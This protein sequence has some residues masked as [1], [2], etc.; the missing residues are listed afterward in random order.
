M[1]DVF[2]STM[3]APDRT[4]SRTMDAS[5]LVLDNDAE[6]GWWTAISG[7][8]YDVSD[9]RDLHSGGFRII[10]DN[11]GIDSAEE[12]RTIRH[13]EDAEIQAML[14]LYRIGRAA[15]LV[16]RRRLGRRARGRRPALCWG[17]R[18]KMATV[19]LRRG[20]IENALRNEFD[21][22]DCN[23]PHQEAVKT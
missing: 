12:Y 4:V 8:V 20:E 19:A 22:F 7:L 13:H 14:A 11:A 2:T 17:T 23:S 1:T 5:E 3:T 6:R 9:F 21:S 15:P 18:Y 16:P 10:D